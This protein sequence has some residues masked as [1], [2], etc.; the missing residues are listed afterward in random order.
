VEDGD[1]EAWYWLGRC[2]SGGWGV[3]TDKAQ[4]RYWLEKAKNNNG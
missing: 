4:A 3:K 1:P 2:Y